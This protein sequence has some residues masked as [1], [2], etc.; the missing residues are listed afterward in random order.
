LSKLE[1]LKWVGT[2]GKEFGESTAPYYGVNIF[3]VRPERLE[4]VVAN[5]SLQRTLAK[6]IGAQP[7]SWSECHNGGLVRVAWIMSYPNGIVL[8]GSGPLAIWRMRS[9]FP[10]WFQFC[11]LIESYKWFVVTELSSSPEE[12]LATKL[13]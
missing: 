9:F 7:K 12:Y 8:R 1:A 3:D 5:V 11:A 13:P 6:T 2:F 4:A 10:I